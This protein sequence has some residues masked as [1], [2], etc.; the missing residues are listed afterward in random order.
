MF[1]QLLWITPF[2]VLKIMIKSYCCCF[3]CYYYYYYYYYYFFIIII[4]IIPVICSLTCH[5][6]F[7][8]PKIPS[9]LARS[10]QTGSE[11][12]GLYRNCYEYCV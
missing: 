10:V 7:H 3:E 5:H 6:A 11:Q 4:F 2:F 9:R 12:Q 8:K 1:K